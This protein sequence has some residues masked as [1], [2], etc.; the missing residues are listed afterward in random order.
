MNLEDIVKN[1]GKAMP[2][3]VADFLSLWLSG[4]M[5]CFALVTM[6]K[7]GDIR[8]VHGIGDDV[9]EKDVLPRD[10]Y[11]LAGAMNYMID[12]WFVSL[13]GDE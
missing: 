7:D 2:P 4:E 12:S 3:N 10:V 1:S 11:A 9:A 13:R 6:K 5:H 8:M